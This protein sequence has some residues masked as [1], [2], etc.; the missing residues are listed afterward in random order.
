M[1]QWSWSPLWAVALFLLLVRLIEAH[2]HGIY[3]FDFEPVWQAGRAVR[4]GR[5]PYL[6]KWFIYPPACLLV[7]VPLSFLS[8]SAAKMLMLLVGGLALVATATFTAAAF[9]FKV[10]GPVPAIVV[11]AFAFFSPATDAIVLL[12][13]DMLIAA[14]MAAAVYYA[15]RSRWT[16]VAV[17]LG[18]SLAYKPLLAPTVIALMILERRRA[19]LIAVAIPVLLSLAMLPGLPSPS[20]FISHA[21]SMITSA[22]GL[23]GAN[24]S[25]KGV[26][27]AA[28]LSPTAALP[29]RLLL[30][31]LAVVTV[32]ALARRD[33]TPELRWVESAS[34]LMLAAF[35][36]GTLTEGHHLLVLVPLLATIGVPGA[37][38][39]RSWLASLAGVLIAVNDPLP[40]P[41]LPFNA[42]AWAATRALLGL[43]LLVVAASWQTKSV[44]PKA[45]MSWP[46]R[47]RGR[48]VAGAG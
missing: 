8:V 23:N 10:S 21:S 13:A 17:V 45:L 35:V 11:A 26:F 32:V 6:L 12:N 46:P 30:V 18:L 28:G 5:D 42:E 14:A 37:V 4:A 38:L 31:V 25:V 22:P 43:V 39:Y 40:H 48:P 41:R 19:A 34:M 36:G 27:E 7:A 15:S 33:T 2:I 16:A 20:R 29:I 47:R 44:A 9:R 1:R 24:S 3:G